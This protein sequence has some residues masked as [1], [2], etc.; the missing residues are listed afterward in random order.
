MGEGNCA[1]RLLDLG[2]VVDVCSSAAA[3]PPRS[4]RSQNQKARRLEIRVTSKVPVDPF[5]REANE[6]TLS[7]SFRTNCC[8]KQ[9]E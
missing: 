4:S 3:P 9:E 8:L 5:L 2:G 7:R 6:K 1:V